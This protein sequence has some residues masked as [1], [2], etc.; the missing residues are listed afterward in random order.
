MIIPVRCFTCGKVLS[1]KY[2]YFKNKVR[3]LK[4]DQNADE[5]KVIYLTPE[6][7][8]KSSKT[9]EGIVMDELKLG[10]ICFLNYILTHVDI[11]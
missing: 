9:P 5:N 7:I 2:L 4:I 8:Q 3:Q 11:D 10:N 1:D 6:F